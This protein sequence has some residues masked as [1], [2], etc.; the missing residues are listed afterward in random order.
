MPYLTFFVNYGNVKMARVLVEHGALN[1]PSINLESLLD[2]SRRYGRKQ[3]VN[4]LLQQ[5]STD[6]EECIQS[7]LDFIETILSAISIFKRN[8]VNEEDKL[9]SAR[10]SAERSQYII[11]REDELE[12]IV[13]LRNGKLISH[14]LVDRYVNFILQ[15][16]GHAYRV[17]KYFD[18]QPEQVLQYAQNHSPIKYVLGFVQ[19]LRKQAREL[20]QSYEPRYF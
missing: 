6:P 5:E 8:I 18:D 10:R 19:D 2:E 1:N 3:M 7:L 13:D 20:K 15:V 9:S 4:V 11:S 14:T 17:L 16:Y 12:C